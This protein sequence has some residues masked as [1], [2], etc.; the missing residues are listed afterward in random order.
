[1]LLP[2]PELAGRGREAVISIPD[3]PSDIVRRRI[4]CSFNAFSMEYEGSPL[5]LRSSGR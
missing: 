4:L 1:M 5:P 3:L 2:V